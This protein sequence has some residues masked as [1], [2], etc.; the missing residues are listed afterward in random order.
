M[1]HS[2]KLIIILLKPEQKPLLRKGDVCHQI[3]AKTIESLKAYTLIVL[4]QECIVEPMFMR[5]KRQLEHV[6]CTVK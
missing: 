4:L 2:V 5:L 6:K 1:N 3:Q